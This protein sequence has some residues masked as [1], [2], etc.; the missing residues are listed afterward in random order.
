MRGRPA[1]T[2]DSNDRGATAGGGDAVGAADLRCACAATRRL[3]RLLT[4]LYD[5]FL[6][7]AGLETAQFSLMVAIDR[8]HGHQAALGARCAMDKT[9]VS[10]NL[11][12]LERKGWISST[13]GPDRRARHVTLTRAGRQRLAAGLPAWRKAQNQL[14]AFMTGEE[15]TALFRALDSGGKAAQAARHKD[16]LPKESVK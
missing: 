15:W 11:K 3:A 8:Q 16:A 9:T 12:L 4:Q 7:D 10:R 6:R 5:H 2:L 1:T 14:R 13:P